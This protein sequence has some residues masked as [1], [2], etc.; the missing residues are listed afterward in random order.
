MKGAL[1]AAA[2]AGLFAA[3]TPAVVHAKDAGKVKCI[4]HQ[5]VQGQGRLQVGHHSCKGMNDCKGKGWVEST[6]KDCTAK[7]GTVVTEQVTYG[8]RASAGSALGE[9]RFSFLDVDLHDQSSLS[10]PRRRAAHAALRGRS[11]TSSRASTGSRSSAR[12]SWSRAAT[13]ARV[14]RAGARALSGGAARR[15]AVDRLDRSARLRRTSTSSSALA[16]EIEPAWVSDHLCWA[17]RRRP[18]LARS[19]AAALHRGGAGARRRARARRC[20]TSW[21]GQILLENVSSYVT[22]QRL[23]DERVGVPGRAGRGAP[24]AACCSTSTTSS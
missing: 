9:A 16:R 17:R 20:R 12:T 18:L 4:G 14:L 7:K 13:R 10:R 6:E 8:L 22:F 2:V 23:D 1:V 3:A 21:S 19:A 24:T 5:R 15:V 11:S